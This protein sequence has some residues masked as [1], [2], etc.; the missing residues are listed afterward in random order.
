MRVLL[1]RRPRPST[2]ILSLMEIVKRS[3]KSR[4]RGTL[5]KYRIFGIQSYFYPFIQIVDLLIY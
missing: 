4:G 3:D 2:D 5:E 1:Y